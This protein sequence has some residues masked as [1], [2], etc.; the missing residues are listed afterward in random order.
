MWELV[1]QTK[2]FTGQLHMVPKI[3]YGMGIPLGTGSLA[4]SKVHPS[5]SVEVWRH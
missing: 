3:G 1:N 2:M 5:I 4:P